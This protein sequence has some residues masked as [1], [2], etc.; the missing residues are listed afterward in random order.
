MERLTI[1]ELAPYLPFKL[2]WKFEGS[3]EVHELIGIDIT[4]CGIHL[5][6]PYSDYG[7]C[8]IDKGKPLLKSLSKLT[9]EI[10]NNSISIQL[11][12]NLK[13]VKPSELI[14]KHWF[15]TIRE[16]GHF[17]YHIGDGTVIG[18]LYSGVP[19]SLIELLLEWHFDVFGLIDRGLAL[20]IDGKEVE[21]E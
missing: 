12:P 17:S 20:P 9:D 11:E 7:K 18:S 14:Y 1:K 2:Q 4:D 10:E 19:Y 3:D 5:L 15:Y 16:D 6:S 13:K 21:G 8:R